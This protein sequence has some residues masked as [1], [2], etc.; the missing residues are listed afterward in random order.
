MTNDRSYPLT[1]REV[2]IL[3]PNTRRIRYPPRRAV[4]GAPSAAA[5]SV[6]FFGVPTLSIDGQSLGSVWWAHSKQNE[7]L[8]YALAHSGAGFTREAVLRAYMRAKGRQ[9]D[10]VAFGLL[11]G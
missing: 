7:L 4:I 6:R 8:W 2:V 11:A 9:L 10:M 1:A 5:I 3:G